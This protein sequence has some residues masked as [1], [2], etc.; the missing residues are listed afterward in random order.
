MLT[1]SSWGQSILLSPTGDGGFENGSTPAANGWTALTN[2]INNVDT[3]AV[4]TVPVVSAG[5]RCGYVTSDNGVSWT[6]SEVGYPGSFSIIHLYHNVTLPAGESVAIISFKWKAMGEG[7]GAYEGDN[8]KVFFS[9][10]NPSAGNPVSSAYQVGA[11]SYNLN[12]AAWN[13]VNN[14]TVTGTP[15][16]TYRLIFS[17][18]SSSANI[19]NPPAALDEVSVTSYAPVA[20]N[21]API[22]FTPTSVTGTGMTIGWTDNST[23]ETGFRVYRST[24]NITFSQVGSDIPSSNTAGIGTVYSQV[25]T[26]LTPGI[27][28]YYRIAAYF[29][30]ESPYLTGNQ[31]TPASTLYGIKTVGASGNYPTI[32]AAIA[33][34][35]LNGVGP[36]GVTFNVAAGHTETFATATAGYITTTSGA[37]DRPI[38]FQKSGEGANPMITA[39]TGTGISDAIIAVAGCDY[40]T[41]NGI[42]IT[43]KSSNLNTTTQMEWGYAILKSTGIGVDGSQHITIRNSTISLNFTNQTSIGIYSNNHTIADATLPLTVTSLSGTNSDIKIFNNTINC[44]IGISLAGYNDA[45]GTTY[46]DQNNEIGKDGANFITNFGGNNASNAAAYGIVCQYQ[47]NIKIA[48][49]TI[50]S[51]MAGNSLAAQAISLFNGK[52]SNFDIYNNSISIQYSG[53]GTSTFN[54]IVTDMGSAGTTNTVNVYNNSITGC[55]FPTFTTGTVRFMNLNNL[56]V[57]ANIYGN[58]ISNNDVGDGSLSSSGAIMYLVCIKGSAVPGVM[59]IYNNIVSENQ[60]RTNLFGTFPGTYIWASGSGSQLNLYGNSVTNNIARNGSSTQVISSSF[61]QGSVKIYD[62]LVSNITELNGTSNYGISLSTTSGNVRHEIYRNTVRNMEGTL[63]NSKISGIYISATGSGSYTYLYN[64]RISDLR[65]PVATGTSGDIVA[66]INN[67]G[68]NYL[69][70][71]NNSVYLNASTSGVNFHSSAFYSITSSSSLL[72]VRNN[73]FVNTS[74]PAG[75]GI[76]AALRLTSVSWSTYL[77]SLSN[78]NLLYA[79]TPGSSNVLFFDGTN[80][81]QSLLDFKTRMYP[82]ESQSVTEMPPFVSINSQSTDLHLQAVA[83]QCESGGSVISGAYP[84]TTDCDN[85]PRYPNSG[86]PVGSGTPYAPDMGAD[87][88]GGIPND[89]TVPVIT[90]TPLAP[91]DATTDRTLAVTITDGSGV[92]VTGSGLPKLYWKT[93]GAYTAAPDPVVSGNTYTFTFGGGVVTGS[94][95]S[96]YV[97][98]QDLSS[99]PNVTAKPFVGATGYTV[100][101]PACSTAPTTPSTYT[102]VAPFS[103]TFHVGVGKTYATLTAA[104]NDF[105]S[106]VLTGPVTFILDDA[107]YA[108]ETIPISFNANAGSSAVNTLTIKPNTDV[109]PLFSYAPTTAVGIIELNG[110]DFITINGSNNGTNSKNLTIWNTKTAL[111]NICALAFKGTATDPTTNVTIKN[112]ILKSVRV[113]GTTGSS[114]ISSVRFISAGAGFE[115]CVID[116]NSINSA[117]NGI[118][119]WGWSGAVPA[120]NIQI[121]NNTIGSTTSSEAVTGKGIDLLNAD[122]TLIANNEIMG[123]V[124]GSIK[125]SQAGVQIGAGVTNTKISK[126]SIHTFWRPKTSDDSQGCYGIYCNTDA[127]TVTEISNNLIYD[128]HSGGAQPYVVSNNTYGIFFNSGGNTKILHNSINLTG[129][130]LST[131]K[132][133][134]SACIGFM[135]TVVGGNFEIRNNI[136][137]N[138]MTTNGGLSSTG[139]AYGIMLY[140]TPSQFSTLNNNDYFIDGYSGAIAQFYAGTSAPTIN[141]PT[142]E[143][144]Q[145]FTGQE[146]NSVNIDPVFASG[147]DLHQ[148]NAAISKL[149]VYI[150]SVPTDIAGTSHTDPADLGAYQVSA[151]QMVTTDAATFAGSDVSLNGTVNPAGNVVTTGFE[152]GLTTS[153]GTFVAATPGS[154]SGLAPAAIVATVTGLTPGQTYNYRAVGTSGAKV[155][156]GGNMTFETGGSKTL[157]VKVYLEGPYTGSGL[158]TTTLNSL[159]PLTSPY[160]TGET[161]TSIPNADIVD[162]VLVEPRIADA[163]ANATSSTKLSG[164]PKSCFLKKDGSIVALDGTSLPEVGNPTIIPGNYMYV[165]VRH[166][167]HL[168]VMS[169]SGLSLEVNS[170]VYDF[171][172]AITQAYGGASGYKELRLSPGVYGMVDGD[173][174]G[175]L[176]IGAND[177]TVWSQNIGLGGYAATDIDMDA[178][179]GANDFTEWSRVIGLNNSGFPSK[180]HSS[181]E[182]KCQVP[183]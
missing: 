159:L 169:N 129:D 180:S 155:V 48:Y 130:F 5:T 101:P 51:S 58:T 183:K 13:S 99:T 94:T 178:D 105:N 137:R 148:T 2:Q 96:Y 25:Q 54:G 95:V 128:I 116:N 31:A 118:Q 150:S 10:T 113:D 71:Y 16:S 59:N 173:A 161:V 120:K 44:F 114:G 66:G 164:W 182:Y 38:V 110:I 151:A 42:N 57:T 87:E 64:N 43:E 35:N 139:K 86:Y 90:Y 167:N 127:S 140:T 131:T 65:A 27:T 160:G 122:N 36:G 30:L 75:T 163:P 41:F 125:Q 88:F 157:N 117:Y 84:V 154:L 23:N 61:T 7:I 171:T 22:N 98:A 40:V 176:D 21:A 121:T 24:D 18:Y 102:I 103:G 3:W 52:N 76:T 26:G 77:S 34:L 19:V 162:W 141:Y 15:G 73:I 142:L 143:A 17:W 11:A 135:N 112:C 138:G 104:A 14:I 82:R 4:G 108:S 46:L 165:V 32:A 33:A 91:T 68:A 145:A 70:V 97:V 144:W 55:T 158:M 8:L 37:A 179:I 126:N 79:G 1:G 100:N 93:S 156:Y 181:N 50:N 177:F 153:Y 69:G 89:L 80:K 39:P 72:D 49:N 132:N 9:P 168:S 119:L 109:S 174:D 136:L 146:A 106:K 83:T 134:S 74:T 85:Q 166:R 28:Y 152:Y 60:R 20:A 115:N 29:G 12:S 47:N 53:P 6:Y 172:T 123:P 63:S 133:A 78:N 62:N 67:S 170:F 81:D 107:S 175:D 124:D 56:G 111:N 92:P 147:T 149:G 45:N